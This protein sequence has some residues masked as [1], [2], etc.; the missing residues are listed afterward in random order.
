M[1]RSGTGSYY[2]IDEYE[3]KQRMEQQLDITFYLQDLNYVLKALGR[4]PYEQ[5]APLIQNIQQQAKDQKDL[6]SNAP[7]DGEF[8]DV[9]TEEE[10]G[11]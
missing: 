6:Q 3:E 10:E 2:N 5:A 7:I 11:C 9:K 4:M 8:E 1:P